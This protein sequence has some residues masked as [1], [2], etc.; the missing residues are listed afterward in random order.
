VIDV[1]R[2]S[3]GKFSHLDPSLLVMQ[4]WDNVTVPFSQSESSQAET[5]VPFFRNQGTFQFVLSATFADNASP[6]MC[7]CL[8]LIFIFL[9]QQIFFLGVASGSLCDSKIEPQCVK[10]KEID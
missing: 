6:S 9:F 2:Q 4:G 7:L 3:N 8:W 1:P 10:V 5:H